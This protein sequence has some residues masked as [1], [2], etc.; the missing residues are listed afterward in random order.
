MLLFW[1]NVGV[2]CE[3]SGG[4]HRGDLGVALKSAEGA[5]LSFKA[6]SAFCRAIPLPCSGQH[7]ECGSVLAASSTGKETGFSRSWLAFCWLSPFQ[8]W[9]L[10]VVRWRDSV[11]FVVTDPIA[12]AEDAG[13]PAQAWF[14]WHCRAAACCVLFVAVEIDPSTIVT[15]VWSGQVMHPCVCIVDALNIHCSSNMCSAELFHKT[16]AH[17]RQDQTRAPELI[18]FFSVLLKFNKAVDLSL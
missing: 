4:F 5:P 7:S 3:R 14:D 16:G 9:Q 12:K 6:G 1:T 15:H 8:W 2:Q 17:M 13:G 10:A 11:G 18:A